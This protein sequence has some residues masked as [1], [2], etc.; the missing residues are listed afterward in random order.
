MRA[1][2]RRAVE[3]IY[4][5]NLLRSCFPFRVSQDPETVAPSAIAFLW[6]AAAA[7]SA[8]CSLV[9]SLPVVDGAV[10]FWTAS[11][12]FWAAFNAFKCSAIVLWPQPVTSAIWRVDS[13]FS[14][15]SFTVVLWSGRDVRIWF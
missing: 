12:R 1:C 8:R 4:S 3:K 15:R 14:A 5:V 13:P 2:D 9:S 10:R 6:A 7:T 11:V